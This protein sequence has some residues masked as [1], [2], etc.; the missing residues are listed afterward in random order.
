[1]NDSRVLVTPTNQL[2]ALTTP[3]QF[4]LLFMGSQ[5]RSKI[6][7]GLRIFTTKNTTIERW[8]IA[9]ERI[10]HQLYLP[11]TNEGCTSIAS[12]KAVVEICQSNGACS[13]ATSPNF[14]VRKAVNITEASLQMKQLIDYDLQSE[15]PF[16]AYEKFDALQLETCITSV[17]LCDSIAQKLMSQLEQTK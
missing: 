2:F 10:A 3:V 11:S 9:N 4:T 17:G 1:M 6:R 7:F 16:D 8:F 14:S 12:L 5:Q 15:L 13:V